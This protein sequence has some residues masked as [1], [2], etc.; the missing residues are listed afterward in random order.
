MLQV[1]LAAVHARLVHANFELAGPRCRRVAAP[2]VVLVEG[3][4]VVAVIV[5]STAGS[6]DQR[7]NYNDQ[8]DQDP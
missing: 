6:F 7:V 3:V 4:K 1:R 5:L 8:Q 2:M